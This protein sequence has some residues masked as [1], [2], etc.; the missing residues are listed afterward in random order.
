MGRGNGATDFAAG[1]RPP[2]GFYRG[3]CISHFKFPIVKSAPSHLREKRVVFALKNA[4]NPRF[5]D[6]GRLRIRK[7]KKICQ[8]GL[9]NIEKISY[10]CYNKL[11]RGNSTCDENPPPFVPP[12]SPV[13]R[14]TAHR[15]THLF[16]LSTHPTAALHRPPRTRWDTTPCPNKISPRIGEYGS[17]P[18]SGRQGVLPARRKT[19]TTK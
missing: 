10:L 16:S 18:Y 13:F 8:K 9:K 11:Y 4:P 2:Y 17:R 12:F 1:E 14:R 15:K 19:I 5:W 6:G 3:G 7:N